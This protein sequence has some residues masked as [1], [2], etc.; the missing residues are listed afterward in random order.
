MTAGLASEA[1]AKELVKHL[2]DPSLFWSKYPVT[3]SAMNEPLLNL[4]GFG[5]A[6]CG[7]QQII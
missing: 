1:Q 4:M 5:V 2:T 6:T 7:L 3:T